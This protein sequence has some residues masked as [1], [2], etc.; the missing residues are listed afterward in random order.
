V[1]KKG[2]FVK[3]DPRI[4]RAGRPQKSD[5][6]RAMIIE[7]LHG[8]FQESGKTCLEHILDEWMQDRRMYPL[9][10]EYAYGKPGKPDFS[11]FSVFD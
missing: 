5:E 2:Q 1:G 11:L 8:E 4:N 7:R 9:L 10:L 6:L 3:N